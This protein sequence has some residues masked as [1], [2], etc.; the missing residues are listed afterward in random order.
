MDK[1]VKIDKGDFSKGS[2]HCSLATADDLLTIGFVN[3]DVLRPKTLLKKNELD[4]TKAVDIT[5]IL[6]RIKGKENFDEV[7][8]G[9][10]TAFGVL[11]PELFEKSHE[12]EE[13][14]YKRR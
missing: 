9:D 8:Q 13:I 3:I 6:R 2:I 1:T 5:L 4:L 14:S 7:L 11:H 10:V 12:E